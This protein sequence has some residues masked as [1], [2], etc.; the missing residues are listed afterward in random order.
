M[1]E[2][3]A[4]IVVFILILIVYRI[5]SSKLNAR[6]MRHQ[7]RQ[8]LPELP[9]H[10]QVGQKYRVVLNNATTFEEVKFLGIS[11]SFDK[12]NVFLPFP[13][14]RWLILERPGG[15]RLFVKP[16][17]VRFYEEI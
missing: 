7:L 12:S 13:L 6:R 4:V 16:E 11:R 14:Q 8:L 3:W 1:S 15:K 17:S 10:I 2:V 5:I 9:D